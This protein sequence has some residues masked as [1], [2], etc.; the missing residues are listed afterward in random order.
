MS[1]S[2]V[3]GTVAGTWTTLVNKAD[4]GLALPGRAYISVRRQMK[5]NINIINNLRCTFEGAKRY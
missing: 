3:P 2:Y 5:K 4:E 1:I